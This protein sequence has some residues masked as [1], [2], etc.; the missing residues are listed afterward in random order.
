MYLRFLTSLHL[1]TAFIPWSVLGARTIPNFG[2][3]GIFLHFAGTHR[4]ITVHV[5]LLQ[6]GGDNDEI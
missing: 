5:P 4:G 2:D 3:L 6:V 1:K